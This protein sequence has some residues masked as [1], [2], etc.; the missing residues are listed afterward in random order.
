MQ[1]F[2]THSSLETLRLKVCL[3]VTNITICYKTLHN[4]TLVVCYSLN[5]PESSRSLWYCMYYNY[6]VLAMYI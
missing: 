3:R 1:G 5:K 6:V 4:A 2:T